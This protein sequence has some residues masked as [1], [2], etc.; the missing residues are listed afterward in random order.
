M[1]RFTA[2]VYLVHFILG[3]VATTA[4]YPASRFKHHPQSLRY[5][6]A[7]YV[8]SLETRQ[9]R[10]RRRGLPGAVYVCTDQNFRGDC[11]W[12]MPST[13]CHIPGTANQAPESIGPDPGGFCIL[14]Q[15]A[16]CT[17]NQIQTLRY[18]GLGSGIPTFGAL[19]CYADGS[20]SANATSIVQNGGYAGSG[21][22]TAGKS[23][24]DPRLAGG[25]GSA[26]RKALKSIMAE[27]E[28]DGFKDGLIGLKKGHYY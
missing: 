24:A 20:G 14:F 26:E 7:R 22:L 23:D 1:I 5:R 10:L 19:K 15:K 27:M 2:I 18:P 6:N 4:A 16:D 17:G 3:L 12:I 25:V 13:R 28:L 9:S 11:S 8:K 21:I